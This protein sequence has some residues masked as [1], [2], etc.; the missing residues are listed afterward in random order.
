MSA[1]TTSPQN[2]KSDRDI[3]ALYKLAADAYSTTF[4]E[5]RANRLTST[6]SKQAAE[7]LAGFSIDIFFTD[8]TDIA[9]AVL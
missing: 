8:S 3:N 2:P 4:N 6:S 9:F 1:S 7:M 5:Q